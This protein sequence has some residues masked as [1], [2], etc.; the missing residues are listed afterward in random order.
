MRVLV[1]EDE[2]K[3]ASF[4]Q[5]GLEAEHYAVEVVHDGE[6]ALARALPGDAGGGA[7]RASHRADR[8]GV[9]PAG[10]LPAPRRAGGK[11][12]GDRASRV[13]RR[14]RYVHQRHRRVRELSAQEDRRRFRAEAAAHGAGRRLRAQGAALLRLWPHTLRGRLIAWYTVLLTA[15]LAA[16]GTTALVL[17]DRSLR[18]NVDT[19]LDALAQTIAES[20]RGPS[21]M[22]PAL[23]ELVDSLLGPGFAERFFRLLDPRGHPDPRLAPRGGA[24]LP[25]STE[26]LR[27]AASG[28]ATYET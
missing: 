5:R 23:D 26:A 20:V 12:C 16:L 2:H 11:P 24:Q 1:A 8:Q 13:G 14:L 7:R 22:D 6:A 27:N 9:R 15:T 25:L 21:A 19:S 28:R 10:I 18:A 3:V 17:L 4:I